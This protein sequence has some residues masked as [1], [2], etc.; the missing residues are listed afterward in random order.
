MPWL[1]RR[2]VQG[3]AKSLCGGA[4]MARRTKL[5]SLGK[6]QG[7]RKSHLAHLAFPTSE[8]ACAPRAEMQRRTC[9]RWSSSSC[10]EKTRLQPY[11]ATL[12]LSLL[13]SD[14]RRR[15]SSRAPGHI[16]SS[17]ASG[18]PSCSAPGNLRIAPGYAKNALDSI[19]LHDLT[20]HDI[21]LHYNT[22]NTLHCSA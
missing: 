21:A 8:L 3:R 12:P 5:A 11:L 1:V 17:T 2:R 7:G 18:Q 20:S 6:T 19:T 22:Y 10:C 15:L 9:S 14:A 4:T 16:M 13:A